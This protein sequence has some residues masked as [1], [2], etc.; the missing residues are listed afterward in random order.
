MAVELS[1]GWSAVR[2]LS[3]GRPGNDPNGMPEV[4]LE[5]YLYVFCK[6]LRN[7]CV[8]VFLALQLIVLVV[9]Q[10]SSGL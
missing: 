1:A 6:Y 8:F 4:V 3:G 10:P 2:V 7:I 9:S 5:T